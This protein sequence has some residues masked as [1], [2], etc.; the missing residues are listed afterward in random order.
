MR[1]LSDDGRVFNTIEECKEHES[2]GRKKDE[3]ALNKAYNEYIDAKARAVRAYKRYEELDKEFI[4]KYDDCYVPDELEH[5]DAVEA[6]LSIF[7]M[8]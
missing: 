7:G 8:K 2:G 6:L 4:E 3:E 1:Y 5:N